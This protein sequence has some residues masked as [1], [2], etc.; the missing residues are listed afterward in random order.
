MG[1]IQFI[2]TARGKDPQEAFTHAV[3]AAIQDHGFGG[4]SGTIAEK[5]DYIVFPQI[6]DAD[7][8]HVAQSLLDNNYPE[9]IDKWGP[10]G[11]IHVK[12]DEYLFFGW[13]AK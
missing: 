4:Y 12:D 1:A 6:A 13:A 11:C 3:I 10:A 8:H 7:P 9:I 2:T 5:P